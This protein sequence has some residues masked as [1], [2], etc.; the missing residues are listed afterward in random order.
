M[1]LCK[2]AAIAADWSEGWREVTG[3]TWEQWQQDRQRWDRPKA[4]IV[5]EVDPASVLSRVMVTQPGE[6]HVSSVKVDADVK[7]GN[8]Q[9]TMTIP[10]RHVTV[11]TR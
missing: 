2:R 5:V 10:L 8:T 11:S 3:K 4:A 1:A 9:V 6:L 7:R